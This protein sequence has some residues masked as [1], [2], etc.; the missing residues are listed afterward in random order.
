MRAVFPESAGDVAV[1]ENKMKVTLR[2][3]EF[4]IVDVSICGREPDAGIMCDYVDGCTLLD[5][6]G[7]VFEEELTDSEMKLVDDVIWAN[8]EAGEDY[9]D[10]Y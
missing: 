6:E 3:Q 9:A 2:G 1:L 7:R 10:S 4:T 8:Q 5:K